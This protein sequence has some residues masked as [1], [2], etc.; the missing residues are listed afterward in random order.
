M[1]VVK[2]EKINTIRTFLSFGEDIGEA[3]SEGSLWDL[4]QYRV[5]SQWLLSDIMPAVEPYLLEEG[6]WQQCLLA[7]NR[8]WVDRPHPSFVDILRNCEVK[9]V[10]TNL[11]YFINDL[12]NKTP[13]E[14]YDHKHFELLV[15]GAGGLCFQQDFCDMEARSPMSLAMACGKSFLKFYNLLK[16]SP[17][18]IREVVQAELHIQK[19]SGWTEDSLLALFTGTFVDFTP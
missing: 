14:D 8:T 16:S 6:W 18:D 5:T 4:M 19:S 12:H 1:S 10:R 9:A 3:S 13:L 7:C 2:L 17:F 15:K 11:L